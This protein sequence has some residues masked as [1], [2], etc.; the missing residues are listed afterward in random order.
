MAKF[1]KDKKAG[2]EEERV[3]HNYHSDFAKKMESQKEVIQ[4]RKYNTI[5][6]NKISA[7]TLEL[8]TSEDVKE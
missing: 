3:V 8:A 7:V 5:D 1:E 4:T 2:F 6:E